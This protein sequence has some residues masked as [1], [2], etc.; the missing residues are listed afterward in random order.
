M[1]VYKAYPNVGLT[2]VYRTSVYWNTWGLLRN[3]ILGTGAAATNLLR[4]TRNRPH[5]HHLVC[6][7]CKRVIDYD[8]FVDEELELLKRVERV[9]SKKHGF[10]IVGHEIQFYGNCL[11]CKKRTK[12]SAHLQRTAFE[13]HTWRTPMEDPV[14]IGII[15]I[16]HRYHTCAGGRWLRA[17][18]N[19]EGAFRAYKDKNVELVGYTTCAGC[20][21][22]NVKY[23][24]A[25]MQK[26]GAQVIHFA[27][28]LVVGYPPCP[29]LFH[30]REFH[31]GQVRNR[32]CH[33][34]ASDPSKL[35]RDP[36]EAGH[37]GLPGVEDGH[38]TDTN[39]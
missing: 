3:C 27:T 8:D 20:P 23:A 26:N 33:G 6:S 11:R 10:H 17:F 24:P 14:K 21:G 34:N 1:E 38:S 37:M 39:R 31:Q 15:T 2:T 12:C 30:F 9:L 18:H 5:H 4:A 13:E 19:H 35:F 22:G 7:N 28:G 36:H 29:Y 25:E 32:H 16:C